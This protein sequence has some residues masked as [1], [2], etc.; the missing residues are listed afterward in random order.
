MAGTSGHSQR[1]ARSLP[2]CRPFHYAP[3]WQEA[4][5][6]FLLL[7]SRSLRALS[8]RALSPSD[9]GEQLSA[10]QPSILS[11]AHMRFLS[12]FRI[13][14]PRTA[15]RRLALMFVAVSCIL[16]HLPS[17]CWLTW[18]TRL[19]YCALHLLMTACPSCAYL[20]LVTFPTCTLST[21]VLLWL[22][23]LPLPFVLIHYH[24]ITE[25]KTHRSTA[26]TQ[27]PL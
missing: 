24:T 2:W 23:S 6:C 20:P 19:A 14:L 9:P 16:N 13:M 15:I 4:A 5:V 26:S 18:R 7:S 27:G 17:L 25:H 1:H 21:S 11:G 3:K 22:S 12:F 8:A 10:Q